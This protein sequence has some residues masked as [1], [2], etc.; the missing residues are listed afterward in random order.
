[1]TVA[2]NSGFALLC[3]LGASLVLLAFFLWV[4]FVWLRK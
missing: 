4:R 1:M 2:D 3:C